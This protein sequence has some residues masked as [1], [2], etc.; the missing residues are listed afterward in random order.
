LSILLPLA[1]FVLSGTASAA[2]PSVTTN[3]ASSVSATAATLSGTVNPNSLAT[4][5]QF[6]YGTTTAYGSTANVALSPNN[7]STSLNVSANLTGLVANTTYHF[8]LTASNADGTTL[9]TNG[10]F[11]T[12]GV[13]NGFEYTI[14]SNTVTITGYSGTGGAVS[15]P[16]TINGLPVTAVGSS[17]FRSK[18]TITSVVMPVGITSIGS[19]A[20]Y[21]CTRLTSVTIPSSVTSIGNSAFY[22]CSGLRSVS[23]PVGVTTIGSDAFSGCT[24]LTSVTIPASVTSIGSDAFSDCTKLTSVTLPASVTSIGSSA[25]SGCTGLTSV[26]IPV[27]VTSISSSSFSGCTGLTSVTIPASVTSIGSSAFRYCT[28]LTS[29]TIPASVTSIGSFAF[30]SCTALTSVTIPASVTS[31]GISAFRYCTGLTS[32]LFTGNT[33][34]MGSTSFSDVSTIFKVYFLNGANGFTVPI[35]QGYPA[36]GAADGSIVTHPLSTTIITGATATL[37]VA[38]IGTG[39]FTY[40]WYEGA[41]GITSKPVGTNSPRFTTPAVTVATNYW[42]K[43]SSA[44]NPA[45]A[46][47]DTATISPPIAPSVTT[48]LATWGT[49]RTVTLTGKVNPNSSA[50][51]AQFEYGTTTDYGSTAIVTLSPNNQS[52]ALNVS[53]SLVTLPAATIYHYR[54][55]ASNAVG[56]TLGEDRV[57]V[58]E[59]VSGDYK[60]ITVDTSA[61]ITDYTGQGG[62]V[63]IPTT[64]DGLP[65]TGIGDL[66]F[67]NKTNITSV[68]IPSSVNSIGSS[69]FS[70]CTALKTALYLGNAPVMGSS[71]FFNVNAGFMSYFISG[72]TG[73]PAPDSADFA[74]WQGYPLGVLTAE[75]LLITRPQ[76]LTITSGATATLSVAAIG[77]GSFAYQW[78]QGITGTTTTPVGT[79]S[80]S[81][82]TPALTTTTSYWVKIT[83][84]ANPI[85][86]NSN[87]A[88]VTVSQRLVPNP[89]PAYDGSPGRSNK[90]VKVYI[91]S[92]DEGM[93][94]FGQVSGSGRGTLNTIVNQENLFPNLR[95]STGGW[96]TR[97]DV[98]V[99]SY[100]T[101]G[102]NTEKQ[103]LSPTWSR[104]GFGPELGFGHVMGWYHD[105][106]VLLIRASNGNRALGWDLLPPGSQRFDWTDG[107][108]YPAYGESAFN[109]I[110]GSSPSPVAWYAGKEF[111]DYFLDEADMGPVLTWQDGLSYP[112][113]VQIRHNGVLYKCNLT[114]IATSASEPGIGV[115][116]ATFWSV[117]SLNNTVDFLDNFAT[118]YPQWAAQGFEIAGY[119]WW[120]GWR[121][122]NTD[123]HTAK[124]QENMARCINQ[125]RSYYATRYPTQAKPD[126]PFVLATFAMHGWSQIGNSLQIANAQLAVDGDAGN[127]PEFAGNVSTIEARGYYRTDAQ[128]PGSIS[129]FY[130]DNAETYMLVGEALGRGM[131]HLL[132]SSPLPGT[133][134]LQWTG[135][136]FLGILDDT[137]LTLDFDGGGLPTGIEWVSGGDPTDS[138]DDAHLSPSFESTGDPDG[139]FLFSYRRSN[140]A[141]DDAISA[142]TV[143]Y[144][145]GLTNWVTAAHQGTGADNITITETTDYFGPNI[146]KVTVALPAS[147]GVNGKIF[148]RLKI[149]IGEP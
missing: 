48:G 28:G 118:E 128:S 25:F 97:N 54:L 85:G 76:S 120:Q 62:A 84:D 33:P 105:E 147:L 53:A 21:F 110:T 103:A 5:A 130:N 82:T 38:A 39:S 119:V 114:H 107:K 87:T 81:F 135:G 50:T 86:V 99:H 136:P 16:A 137:S 36:E 34:T 117:Y 112:I 6:T 15:I 138:R 75:P 22:R 9:G 132:G 111:D 93:T 133:T 44:A 17:A 108:T 142:I 18:S 2:A 14:A 89:T 4:T 101:Q 52:T 106:P 98:L 96:V 24:A 95:N 19:D 88:K 144:G 125:L 140:A 26:S 60:Y 46:N 123:A 129:H 47:S 126:A 23:I 149:V 148:A 69:A 64:I 79:N 57:L 127:Y 102:S 37:T 11:V 35:W 78:Y 104:G 59:R 94:S 49:S 124:Y 67:S 41:S 45:G 146:D 134:Y 56:T 143:E 58:T 42:V 40:Q 8:Q 29:V 61:T 7:G 65:V 113:G 109:W 72:N 145:N 70:N 51:T 121:D 74:L 66:A 80:E 141:R 12:N 92:G 13:S 43:V 73:F 71:T 100:Q 131:V 122:G 31:I 68:T 1:L 55:T 3:P 30:S 10:V 116:G 91:M 20:F 115:D 90:P 27:G 139:K 77:T 63:A 32:A 83:N